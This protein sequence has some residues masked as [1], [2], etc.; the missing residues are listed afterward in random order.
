LSLTAKCRERISASRAA[1]EDWL[2]HAIQT[3][4]S[5]EEQEELATILPLLNRLADQ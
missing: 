4:L 1:K 5:P 2:F 3:K